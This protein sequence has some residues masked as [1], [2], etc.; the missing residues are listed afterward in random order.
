MSSTIKDQYFLWQFS[1]ED[2]AKIRYQEYGDDNPERVPI[3]FL[4]G[5]GGMIEHWNLNIP[6]FAHRYKIYAMDLIGF[7]FVYRQKN[8]YRKAAESLKSTRRLLILSKRK[9]V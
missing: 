5:Y 8:L 4:H 2:E 7:G 3:L 6:Q 1:P 9:C